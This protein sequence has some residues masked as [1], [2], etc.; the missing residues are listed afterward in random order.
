MGPLAGTSGGHSSSSQRVWVR[1]GTS[2]PATYRGLLASDSGHQATAEFTLDNPQP[3]ALPK[4]VKQ[5]H[6]HILGVPAAGLYKGTLHITPT[7]TA[8]VEL[9]AQDSIVWPVLIVFLG[10]LA[11]GG[12]T[13]WWTRRRQ[14]ELLKAKFLNAL[15]CYERGVA[16]LSA[17]SRQYQL[18]LPKCSELPRRPRGECPAAARDQPLQNPTGLW[19]WLNR[20]G[21]TDALAAPVDL[22]SEAVDQWLLIA[23]E[24][25]RV[26]DL[27]RGLQQ[28]DAGAQT[29][30]ARD[31]ERLLGEAAMAPSD[32]T[33]SA[34]F[35]ERL[36]DQANVLQ[37]FVAVWPLWTALDGQQQS[38]ALSSNPD[39]IYESSG[40]ARTRD[41][42]GARNLLISLEEAREELAGL[43]VA[44]GAIRTDHGLAP[45]L[46]LT[47]G[48]WVGDASA[49]LLA[50]V[51]LA[52]PQRTSAAA[53]IS[54]VRRIDWAIV[55]VTAIVTALAYVLVI[56]TNTEFGTLPQYLG[57]FA[58]GFLGQLGGLAINWNLFSPAKAGDGQQSLLPTR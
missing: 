7:V 1:V 44:A 38:K 9:K 5:G 11:G 31:T 23:F 28:L 42:A 55:I 52:R 16:G 2:A 13:E 29:D 49:A 4:G 19:C 12:G 30:A 8:N 58:A 15:E 54:Q 6:V 51:A 24:V 14:R 10:A 46:L 43:E 22:V 40:S 18:G 41:H 3:T 36:R 33:S 25:K 45:S 53:L 32:A 56:Y 39:T 47:A 50:R 17:D 26:V 27:S 21:S 37:A 20:A 57:A 48:G 34:A 35:V